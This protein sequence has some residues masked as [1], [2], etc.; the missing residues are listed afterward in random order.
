MNKLSQSLHWS[1]GLLLI[2]GAFWVVLYQTGWA[3][4]ELG[5][6]SLVV[7][8]AVVAVGLLQTYVL[9]RLA[10]AY[11]HK[12]GGTAVYAL[13]LFGGRAK[14]LAFLSGWGYWLAWTPATVLN[15]YLCALLINNALA[16]SLNPTWLCLGIMAFL[17]TLNWFG[18]SRV[19]VSSY[20]LAVLVLVPLLVLLWLAWQTV[21]PAQWQQALNFSNA[22]SWVVFLKWFFVIAWTGYGLEM[23]SSVVAE[24]KGPPRPMFVGASLWSVLAFVGIPLLLAL[25]SDWSSLASDPF[26]AL[27]PLFTQHLGPIGSG[28]L[29]L[30]LL[31]ALLYSAL[32]IL[33]PST[34]TIYQM[35]HDGLLPTY[36]GSLNRHGTPQGSLVLDIILNV[37]L[38]L[39]FGANLIAILAVANVGYMVVFILLPVA[40][41]LFLKRHGQRSLR[42][43]ALA[44]LL[45]LI[46]LLVMAVGGSAWGALVFGVGWLLVGVGIPLY[47]LS[48]QRL[49]QH[50][51]INR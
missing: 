42:Q 15:S 13:E 11:P 39:V 41:W 27:Q 30:F 21:T 26:S 45:L 35:S 25:L 10:K 14:V 19:I 36:F 5:A 48:G 33:I 8:A 22:P 24:T 38:L 12:A 34:R 44:G 50:T 29:M 1:Q 28:V 40:Y 4:S 18:L 32:A 46:N 49:A 16:I 2:S 31:A 43:Y 37:G 23:I 7:W 3:L 9:Y 47:Y 51:S 6:W 20:V 17:Y